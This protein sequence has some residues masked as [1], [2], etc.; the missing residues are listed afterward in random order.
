MGTSLLKKM[1]KL[2]PFAKF[3]AAGPEDP[4]KNKHCFFCM[5]CKKNISINSR[6]LNQLKRHYQ[7][8]WHLRND[9]RFREGYCFGK[10]RGRDARVL[11]GEKLEI[12]R[13]QYVELDVPDLCQKRPLYY[14]VV[15]GKPFMFTIESTRIRIQIELLPIFLKSGGQLWALDGYWTQVGV[16]T[17]H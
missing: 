17:G 4:L 5:L 10:V 15:D 1:L 11:Y 3:F 16:L 6:G 9:Q 8:D 12:G 14:D 13:E 2:A 7:R